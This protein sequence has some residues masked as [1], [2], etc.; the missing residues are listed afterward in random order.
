MFCKE[1]DLFPEW[2]EVGVHGGRLLHKCPVRL[3]IRIRVIGV[4]DSDAT[5]LNR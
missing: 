1:A 2:F 3:Y 4:D 5:A